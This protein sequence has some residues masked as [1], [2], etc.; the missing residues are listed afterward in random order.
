MTGRLAGKVVVVIGGASGIGRAVAGR[1]V[2]EG[3]AVVIAGWRREPGERAAA[4][5]PDDA[6][7]NAGGVTAAAPGFRVGQ[8]P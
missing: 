6:V 4:Q 8:H 3:S 7:N 1:V 5:L 2:A